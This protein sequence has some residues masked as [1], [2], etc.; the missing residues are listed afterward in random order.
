MDYFYCSPENISTDAVLIDGEEFAH[1]VHVMRKKIGDEIRVVDGLGIAYDVTLV[2]M[3]KR[4]A[5]GKI[6]SRFENYNEP[7]FSL[8]LAIGILKNPSRFDFLVEKITDLGVREIIPMTTVRTIPSHAKTD[9][10]Q[11]LALAAMKQCGRG[12]L[13]HV[14]SLLALEK[15]LKESSAFKHKLIAH[16]TSSS[17]INEYRNT[18]RPNESILVL[19]G[20]EGGFC[21]EEVLRCINSGFVDVSLGKR[22]LRTE[23]AAIIATSLIIS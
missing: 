11:K 19:I 16:E 1:L 5:K 4:E 10:W 22:R 23:T 18:M 6:T 12:Y 9:R 8:T 15:V 13:P 14:R 7:T 17:S 3:K 20:P 2:E 21:E